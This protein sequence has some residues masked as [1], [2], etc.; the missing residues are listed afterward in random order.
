MAPFIIICFGVN[1]PAGVHP[2][3]N[4][5]PEGEGTFEIISKGVGRYREGF[6]RFTSEA[7][8][9]YEGIDS[10][11][12]FIELWEQFLFIGGDPVVDFEA[13]FEI[14]YGEIVYKVVYGPPFTV[15]FRNESEGTLVICLIRRLSF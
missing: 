11:Q 12:E 4:L 13:V 14:S 2:H 8:R 5:P 6:V 3:P 15:V 7:R 10:P 1:Y 9:F